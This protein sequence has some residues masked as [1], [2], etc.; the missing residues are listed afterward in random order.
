MG[1]VH[2][3]VGCSSH[4][5]DGADRSESADPQPL[6]EHQFARARNLLAAEFMFDPWSSIRYD[7]AP[8]DC[9]SRAKVGRGD[10]IPDPHSHIKCFVNRRRV[11]WKPPCCLLPSGS[12]TS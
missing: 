4:F 12:V 11:T 2:R 7:A 5:V 10:L 8:V 9:Y 1:G 6:T 3:K